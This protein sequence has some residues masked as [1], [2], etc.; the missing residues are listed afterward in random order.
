MASKGR[1][2][3]RS[4]PRGRYLWMKEGADVFNLAQNAQ[5][6]NLLLTGITTDDMAKG[7]SPLGPPE[8]AKLW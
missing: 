1:T 8:L 6:F 3:Y 7:T 4:R 2:R 5:A